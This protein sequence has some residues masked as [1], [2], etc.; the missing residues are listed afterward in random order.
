[1]NKF[2]LFLACIFL[3]GPSCK[4][5]P[6][7]KTKVLCVDIGGTRIK[8]QILHPNMTLQELQETNV[9][10][11]QSHGRLNERLPQLF[12]VN[13]NTSLAQMFNGLYDQISFGITGPVVDGAFYENP[14]RKI[15]R[16]LKKRCSEVALCPVFVENDAIVWARGALIYQNLIKKKVQYPCLAL[17]LGTAAGV[18]IVRSPDDMVDIEIDILDTPFAK[19]QKIAG[20]QLKVKEKNMPWPHNAMGEFYFKWVREY[21]PEWNEQVL[22]QNYNERIIA[23]I[24]DM[25]EYVE[26]HFQISLKQVMIG[27]GNSRFIS[28]RYLKAKLTPGVSLLNA[29]HLAKH[30]VAADVIALL[31]CLHPPHYKNSTLHP[32]IQDAH[33]CPCACPC[34]CTN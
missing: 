6:N 28:A 9:I 16:E 8:A 14:K 4:N 32:A 5:E 15:P 24:E 26:K 10:Y 3:C 17:T 21:Q 31:G 22:C 19:L 13:E 18:V 2:A 25:Q 34:A 29:Q 1:M 27:G 7:V 33:T 20:D 30:K 23:F 12:D 11:L